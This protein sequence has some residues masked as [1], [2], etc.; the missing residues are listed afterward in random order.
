MCVV[1]KKCTIVGIL[2][3]E[4]AKQ[5][6]WCRHC[7]QVAK[8]RPRQKGSDLRY[9]LPADCLHWYWPPHTRSLR[10]CNSHAN[11]LNTLFVA[12]C[13]AQPHIF[14]DLAPP[15]HEVAQ[16]QNRCRRCAHVAKWGPRN[17]G[18]DWRCLLPAACHCQYWPSH[19]RRCV[20]AKGTHML[21][22]R[23]FWQSAYRTLIWGAQGQQHVITDIGPPIREVAQ[24]QKW[25]R[26][27][28]QVAKLRPQHTV[29]I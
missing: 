19:I 17:K 28:A 26:H 9:P 7:A 24:Q 16:Q 20:S 10:R 23:I 27:C 6:K 1:H 5:Q 15:I 18:I 12:E 2:V 8:W 13:Q 14:T 29:A 3:G 21:W 4:V 25:C 11:A 22:I